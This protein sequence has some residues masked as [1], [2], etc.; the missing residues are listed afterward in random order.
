MNNS[1]EMGIN[2]YQN[3]KQIL[4]EL[5][6]KIDQLSSGDLSIEELEGLT[7]L[8]RQQDQHKLGK[9]RPQFHGSTGAGPCLRSEG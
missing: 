1:I 8:G 6:K 4:S 3:M 5:Q 2:T 7:A 9:C